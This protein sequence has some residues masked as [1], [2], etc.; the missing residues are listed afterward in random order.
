MSDGGG[1][2]PGCIQAAPAKCRKGRIMG[3]S[4]RQFRERENRRNRQRNNKRRWLEAQKQ[5]RKAA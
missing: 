5:E 4:G 1:I 3:K 2:S